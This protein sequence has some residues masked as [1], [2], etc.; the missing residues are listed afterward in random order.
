MAASS[1][2]FVARRGE[3]ELVKPVGPTPRELKRLS[4]LDDQESLRFYRSVIYF[5]RGCP[6]RSRADPARVIRG[7]LAAALVYYYP[8]AGRLRELPGGKLVVDCTGEGVCFVEADA[9]VV[10]D[11]FGDRLCPPV[12]C[13]GELLCLPE[14]NSAIVVNRALLYVQVGM[15]D[16]PNICKQVGMPMVCMPMVGIHARF[17]RIPTPYESCGTSSHLPAFLTEKIPETAKRNSKTQT[18]SHGVT[19]Q[20]YAQSVADTLVLRG[21]PRFTMARTYL[22]TDLTRSNLNEVDLGWGKP[23]YGGPATTTL[24]T[25]HIPMKGGGIIVP[26]C[27][28]SRA[29][30]RFA[31]NVRA[32]LSGASSSCGH[33]SSKDS[34]VLSKL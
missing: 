27:L 2:A 20:D 5:Y 4:D 3:P 21:R 7:G 16:E 29:M 8:I 6:S 13:A 30:E 14:S 11:E 31:V 19:T 33:S 9:D 24:A 17:E 10:L 1:L 28:P 22:V 23:V 25:F 32:G 26:M 34:T 18:T 15:P 12:P